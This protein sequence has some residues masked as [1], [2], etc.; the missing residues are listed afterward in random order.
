[1]GP[2]SG[3]RGVG[4]SGP[5]Q[6]VS[7]TGLDRRLR[8]LP[9]FSPA[10]TDTVGRSF[11]ALVQVAMITSGTCCPAIPRTQAVRSRPP[12]PDTMPRS[13]EDLERAGPGATGI[14][15]A[16]NSIARRKAR[17]QDPNG[18]ARDPAAEPPAGS[19]VNSLARS[20]SGG[21]SPVVRPAHARRGVAG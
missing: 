13:L 8:R 1:M 10:S 20:S 12:S 19:L 2:E 18:E 16:R 21:S 14:A 3:A 7:G 4:R 5:A 11:R 15:Q 17:A 9:N 6:I